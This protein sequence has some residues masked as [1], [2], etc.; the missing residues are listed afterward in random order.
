MNPEEIEA[1]G[2]GLAKEEVRLER[3]DA[4]WFV[5]ADALIT[6]IGDSL[7]VRA[8][9][10]EHIGSSSVPGLLA[11]PII[12]IAVMLAADVSTE[13]AVKVLEGLGYEY[14]GDAG[15]AGG[16]V[17]VL[18]VRPNHRVAHLHVLRPGDE[19]WDFYLSFRDRL[20][21]D[22]QARADYEN[23]KR[24]LADTYHHDRKAYT[25]GKDDVVRR[26]R[27]ST[28]DSSADGSS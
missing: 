16:L 23:A 17:F 15:N 18:S 24:A 21:R 6:Q 1:Y 11:K 25:D 8:A 22:A 26:L 12:D 19:Q 7:G 28:A 5:V 2:L 27:V 14:R 9:A 20:R 10:V 13:L 3:G 4:G